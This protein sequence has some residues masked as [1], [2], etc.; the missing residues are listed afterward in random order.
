M[1]ARYTISIELETA[2]GSTQKM[3]INRSA[4][5]GDNPAFVGQEL[6]MKVAPAMTKHIDRMVEN[7]AHNTGV[8][9]NGYPLPKGK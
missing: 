2:D 7:F 8:T 1:E 3:T 5:F 9:Q 6:A 4:D